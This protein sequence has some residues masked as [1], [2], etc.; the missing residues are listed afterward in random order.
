M[1]RTSNL[2]GAQPGFVGLARFD[3]EVCLDD[4]K[5]G[6]FWAGRL[7]LNGKLCL[8]GR[9]SFKEEVAAL[10]SASAGGKCKHRSR[11]GR[12]VGDVVGV[13]DEDKLA[14]GRVGAHRRRSL[15]TAA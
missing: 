9:N 5:W 15:H 2:F 4:G 1:T 10:I 11:T 14:T 13:C 6:C 12:C 8:A 7:Q 3:Q